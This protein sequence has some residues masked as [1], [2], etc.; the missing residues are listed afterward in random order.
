MFS[1]SEPGVRDTIIVSLQFTKLLVLL[2]LL[3]LLFKAISQSIK[4]LFHGNFCYYYYYL[5]ANCKTTT[6][7]T[8]TTTFP[9]HAHVNFFQISCYYFCDCFFL[10]LLPCCPHARG[11]LCGITHPPPRTRDPRTRDPRSLLSMLNGPS[12][13]GL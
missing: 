5:R 2:I 4:L 12:Y 13:F 3:L 6:T 8:T 7:T 9:L 10:L 1:A 11:I